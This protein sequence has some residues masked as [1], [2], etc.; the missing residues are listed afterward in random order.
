V[1]DPGAGAVTHLV[2]EPRHRAGMARLV[3]IGFTDRVA[4][5]VGLSCTLAEFDRLDAAEEMRF[6]PGAQWGSDD[7]AL[8]AWP[9]QWEIGDAGI[10]AGFGGNAT[11]PVVYDRVP[12]GD[13]EVCRGD[14][15]QATDGPIG[16]VHGLVL[17]PGTYSM[18]HILLQEGHLWGRKE[19]AIPVAA[20]A[21]V[22]DGIRLSV[23][24]LEVQNLLSVDLD[25]GMFSSPSTPT[26]ESPE[27]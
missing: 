17:D 19:V 7:E 10:P 24:K 13:V 25:D 2:V 1:V 6:L 8:L 11:P 4:H 5:G 9:T 21:S 12:E 22:T 3:P 26:N 20:V 14:A 15:V 16:R 18:T 27:S 23:T